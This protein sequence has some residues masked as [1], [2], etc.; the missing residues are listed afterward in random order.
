[1]INRVRCRSR[2]Q[3]KKGD[4][5]GE[6]NKEVEDREIRGGEEEGRERGI[7]DDGE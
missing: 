6:G 7:G 1:M 2:W 3:K 5:R 4:S